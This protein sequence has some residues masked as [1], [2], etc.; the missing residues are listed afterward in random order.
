MT[1]ADILKVIN[2]SAADRNRSELVKGAVVLP[3]PAAWRDSVRIGKVL[4]PK[5]D[6]VRSNYFLV[7]QPTGSKAPGTIYQYAVH[8][9]LA[10]SKKSGT[11][12]AP[13]NLSA[14]MD[15]SESTS[16]IISLRKNHPEWFTVGGCAYDGK[17]NVFTTN[18][19]PL[20]SRTAMD[21][22]FISEEIFLMKR[23][24]KT[25][26]SS[27]F[28]VTLTLVQSIPY[29]T[30]W[31]AIDARGLL[32]LDSAVLSFA[33]WQVVSEL[34]EWFLIGSQVFKSSGL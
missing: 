12:A 16:L 7:K 3:T 26:S 19:L 31:S 15:S 22:P 21:E 32:G 9:Y 10:N 1:D 28:K 25:A 4:D 20:P 30:D 33:K 23:D 5:K 27:K 34:P 6:V 24:G 17:S 18:A 11:G 14:T 2:P 8:I 13:E 29:P